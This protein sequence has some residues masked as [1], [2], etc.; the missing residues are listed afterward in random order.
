M[1][2]PVKKRIATFVITFIFSH[3][4][5]A[6]DQYFNDENPFEISGYLETYYIHDANHAPNKKRGDFIYSHQR[7]NAPN[8]NLAFIKTS[9]QIEHLRANLAI[10]SGTYMRA[11]YAAEPTKLQ[12]LFEANVGLKLSE[13]D[14]LWLDIGVMPSHIGFESAIGAENWTLTRSLLADNSP[15]FETGAKISYTTSD[16]KWYISGLLLNGW[17]RIQRPKGNTTPAFGHQLT[18]KPNS[19][20]TLNSSSFIGNDQSDNA[21]QMRYFHNFYGQYQLNDRVS[22]ITGFDI[23]TEQKSTHSHD[24]NVWLAP[25]IIAKYKYSDKLSFSGRYE[26]YQDRNGVIIDTGTTNGFMTT[27]YSVNLDYQLA[28]NIGLRSEIRQLNSKD[29]IFQQDKKLTDSSLIA[30]TALTLSF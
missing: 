10:G 2:R 28:P 26:Y 29:K 17:Q 15:Y 19:K 7:T 14:D 3:Q 20:I 9:F 4:A 1:L 22:V 16:G 24:Y 18:Y 8:I 11:N 5:L 12:K 25:I 27:G 30:V 23:G 6:E 13:D 21:R